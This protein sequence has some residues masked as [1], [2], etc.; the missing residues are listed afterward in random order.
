MPLFTLD[1][2]GLIAFRGGLLR[3][4]EQVRRVKRVRLGHR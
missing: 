3:D 2:G 1:S 4:L